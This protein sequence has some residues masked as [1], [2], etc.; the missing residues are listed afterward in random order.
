[1]VAF[2]YIRKERK[3]LVILQFGKTSSPDKRN[4]LE[5]VR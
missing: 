1:M 3:N 4:F 2:S 5:R